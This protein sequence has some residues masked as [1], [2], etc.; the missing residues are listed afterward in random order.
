MSRGTRATL[1]F[2]LFAVAPIIHPQAGTADPPSASPSAG[3][4]AGAPGPHIELKATRSGLLHV[5][6]AGVSIP[7]PVVSD[8]YVVASTPA[9]QVYSLIDSGEFVPGIAPFARSVSFPAG[10]HLPARA[11][12]VAQLPDLPPGPYAWFAALTAPGTLQPI[13]NVAR[14]DWHVL[15]STD[16]PSL[17]TLDNGYRI[18]FL[19]VTANPDGTSTWRY[20]VEE[21]PSAQDLSN[22]V[23]ELPGCASLLHAAPEPWEAVGPDPNAGLSGIKWETGAGFQAGEFVF[24]LGEQWAVGATRV[25]AKGPDLTF[26]TI[27]GPICEESLD[28]ALHKV[29]DVG[30]ATPGDVVTYAT[31][32]QN[33][34]AT[35]AEGLVLTDGIPLGTTLV[36]G[37][38]HVTTGFGQFMA[39]SNLVFWQGDLVPGQL[40]TVVFS[41]MIEPGVAGGSTITNTVFAGPLHANAHVVVDAP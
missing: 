6:S 13:S 36:P 3:E 15:A 16:V 14:A 34:G 41:V 32:L 37:S 24:T 21:L 12:V 9:G 40:L 22:W 28:L 23:L 8:V 39:E 11:V 7:S 38:L 19:D 33:V 17:V 1:L 25:A 20:R 30:R 26:G 27:A 35:V 2:V 29:A 4:P 18:T 5:L 31:T 10:F